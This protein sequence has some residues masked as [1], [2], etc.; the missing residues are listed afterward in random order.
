MRKNVPLAVV[1]TIA[2]LITSSSFPVLATVE[3]P[4][5]P[6][7]FWLEEN[8]K[9]SSRNR[10]AEL[11]GGTATL[12]VESSIPIEGISFNTVESVTTIKTIYVNGTPLSP[13]EKITL[14]PGV[15]NITVQYTYVEEQR[16]ALF[17]VELFLYFLATGYVY[18]FDDEPR[19]WI[20]LVPP[21]LKLIDVKLTAQTPQ[22]NVPISSCVWRSEVVVYAIGDAFGEEEHIIALLNE[23]YGPYLG[24]CSEAYY[25]R[26]W[27][28]IY[29]AFFNSTSE[30]YVVFWMDIYWWK[31][32]FL[33]YARSHFLDFLRRRDRLPLYPVY[34]RFYHVRTEEEARNYEG[35][36]GSV[37]TR[38]WYEGVRGVRLDYG[39]L[40][41]PWVF[42]DGVSTYVLAKFP[43]VV[44]RGFKVE[45][46]LSYDEPFPN[47]AHII[48]SVIPFIRTVS[49]ESHGAFFSGLYSVSPSGVRRFG[50]VAKEPGVY[51][52]SLYVF[53]YYV[54][55]GWPY[56]Y[57]MKV[58]DRL[59]VKDVNLQVNTIGPLPGFSWSVAKPL[60]TPRLEVKVGNV[61]VH[62]L[63]LIYVLPNVTVRPGIAV[64][65]SFSETDSVIGINVTLPVAVKAL[66]NVQ[67][68]AF[69]TDALDVNATAGAVI[70]QV[71][72]PSLLLFQAPRV[73]V[74]I[75]GPDGKE[76]PF[77]AMDG[78][79]YVAFNASQP[80][81]YRILLTEL[82]SSQ[83][84]SSPPS[85][86][87][88]PSPSFPF[89]LPS[90]VFFALP[91]LSILLVVALFAAKHAVA[92][93][94]KFVKRRR[95]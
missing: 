88:S 75:S 67:V 49:R 51:S 50:F 73:P 80:G 14:A 53:A 89:E 34:M 76:V 93:A 52:L 3:I 86:P 28:K 40:S 90:W 25:D 87:P 15:W 94:G 79:Y 56:L 82:A 32:R 6:I 35:E 64:L 62:S 13:R 95:V 92:N 41:I 18:F 91:M 30:S 5:V 61:T 55:G 85:Q 37:Y 19:F 12:I 48:G 47:A 8:I 60:T 63:P 27:K 23:T 54:E 42:S 31:H 74:S 66:E 17:Y 78:S 69:G 44:P 43:R 71:G 36:T 46:P 7:K 9:I 20:P 84:P 81:T 77:V 24:V 10:F 68:T 83:L 38:D 59:T 58:D 45:N 39:N 22:G 33:F 11:Y 4:R 65:E 72:S 21:P 16:D 1:I 57:G 70:V 29:V 26:D 2:L